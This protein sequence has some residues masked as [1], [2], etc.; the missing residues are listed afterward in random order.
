MVIEFAEPQLALAPGQVA[1]L[2]YEEDR[3]CLGS[4]EITEGI[5]VE[6]YAA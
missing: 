3:W 4:G 1:A 2:Y 5:P 6:K